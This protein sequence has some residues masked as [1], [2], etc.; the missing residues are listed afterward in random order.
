MFRVDAIES[1]DRAANYI[2]EMQRV[3]EMYSSLFD[4]LLRESGMAD[5]GLHC[6]LVLWKQTFSCVLQYDVSVNVGQL[7]CH[8]EV[9]WLNQKDELLGKA[10][11]KGQGP[12][13]LCFGEGI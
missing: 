4:G 2:N 12:T 10:W 5:V 3:S 13:V 9:M 6:F 11:K 1:T 8:G 7:R